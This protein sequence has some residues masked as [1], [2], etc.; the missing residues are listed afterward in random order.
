MTN[1]WVAPPAETALGEAHFRALYAYSMD[2]VV[3][4]RPDGTI[5][6]A[7]PAACSLFGMT[8]ADLRRVGRQGIL[9]D[10]DPA[11]REVLAV[12]QKTGRARGEVRARRGDGS[13]FIAE[14]STVIFID[15][16]GQDYI[17]ATARDV[18]AQREAEN[19][20]RDRDRLLQMTSQVARVGGWQADICSSRVTWSDEVCR[21]HGVE[22]GTIVTLEEGIHYYAPEWQARIRDVFDACAGDGAPYEEELEIIAS[23]GE[24][25]WVRTT[26]QAVRNAA[27][28]ITHVQGAFQDISERKRAEHELFQSRQRFQKFADAMPI[29]VWTADRDG[30]VDF[31]NSEFDRYSGDRRELP[32][33]RWL[34]AVHPDDRARSMAAWELSIQTGAP[35]SV[36]FRVRDVRLQAD[37]WHLVSA[38]PIRNDKGR[39]IKWYGTAIDIHDRKVAEDAVSALAERLRTTL[40]S[41]TDAFFTVDGDWRFTYVNAQAERLLQHRREDLL[42][43]VL[44]EEFEEAVGM[45]FDFQYHRALREQ[46]AV[47]FEEYYPPLDVWVEVHAYPSAEGLAV[48][49]RDISDRRALEEQ[50]RQSQR[51]ESLGQLTG[52]V[53][54][55]FNNLLTVILGGSEVLV[56]RLIPYG[57]LHELADIIHSAAERGSALTRRLLAFGRR[58]PLSPRVV[59]VNE[60]VVG[61][62]ALLRRTVTETIDLDVRPGSDLWP[63]LIDDSEL[64]AALVNLCL[65][66]RDAMNGEGRLTVETANVTLG[67]G[68][69]D[70]HKEVAAGEYVLLAVSDTGCGIPKAIIDKVFD[71]FFTTKEKGHGTGL[72][73]S[74]VYGFVKQSRG[75]VKIYSE[76]EQGTTVKLYLPRADS[77]CDASTPAP[78]GD[79]A[80]ASAPVGG[81]ILLV[82]DDDLVRRH[83]QTLL[84]EL[85]YHVISAANAATALELMKQHDAIDLLFTDVMMPG[86]NGRELAE[87]ARAIQ[88]TVEVLFTYGYSEDAILHHGRLDPSVHLLPKP[89]RRA[90]LIRKLGEILPATD[91]KADV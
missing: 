25:V 65:N 82:E 80:P 60:L 45:S 71:P 69:V 37:R 38:V 49:L 39:I 88:P 7:N 67:Q 33:Q 30:V 13:E 73:L 83:A 35:Y 51:L 41:I 8:E 63:A 48:Y 11:L 79:D 54:H 26:G 40:E 76:P 5:V 53:A 85:G 21:I 74:M 90:D 57:P 15:E 61:L 18:T 68:Y 10:D 91:S 62:D 50:L 20:L 46:Q 81:T 59:D 75:H 86:M 78:A 47:H 3:L 84:R 87:A 19:K 27:G 89:Y 12:R 9:D 44:W 77:S 72:G 14:I 70:C 16:A 22:P 34:N 32:P 4:A 29:I 42:G 31:A 66:A 52:G 1:T 36:E 58:Q 56:E 43:K 2:A 6:S 55:D 64:E 23:G 28:V 24:R 17:S